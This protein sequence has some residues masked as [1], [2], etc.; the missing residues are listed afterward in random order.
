MLSDQVISHDR[1]DKPSWSQLLL[2]ASIH[3]S[4]LAPVD[5]LRGNRRCHIADQNLIVRYSVEWEIINL[6]SFVSF[7]ID[8]VENF[9]S[10]GEIPTICVDS[11]GVAEFL[12][13]CVRHLRHGTCVEEVGGVILRSFSEEVVANGGELH[14]LIT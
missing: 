8:V 14:I 3:H 11:I 10:R 12:C 5:L 6:L 2:G 7:I 4:V 1:D 9:C 13:L